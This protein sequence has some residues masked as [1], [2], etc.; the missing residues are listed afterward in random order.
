MLFKN[1]VAAGKF[2]AEQLKAYGGT[3]TVVVALP[4]GGVVIGA[5][6]SRELKLPLEIMPVCKIRH[7]D[8]EEV[9]IGA[10]DD[11]GEVI[12]GET[13]E[14]YFNSKWLEEE[15]DKQ[16]REAL[17]RAAVYREGRLPID[18]GDKTVI[19]VDDG[20]A[21]GLTMRLAIESVKKQ[22][23]K[24]VIV[25]VPVASEE[26]LEKIRPAV[27]EVLVLDSPEHFKGA[28][29]AHYLGFPQLGD[30]EVL[31]LLRSTHKP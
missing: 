24:K 6:I 12:L 5:I 9:A 28:V 30:D 4:R 26:S 13:K 22:M 19:L 7:P 17:R 11:R 3:N 21:T 31:Q 20:I 10:I 16:L 29:G 27:D 23:P 15:S 18:F 25:A 2:L 1:R 8:S 14:D